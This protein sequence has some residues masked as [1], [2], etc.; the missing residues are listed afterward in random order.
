M[1]G[2][3]N[4]KF[5]TSA[6]GKKKQ[7]EPE[8]LSNGHFVFSVMAL[9][10]RL[11]MHNASLLNMGWTLKTPY[12]VV[13][14]FCFSL[15]DEPSSRKKFQKHEAGVREM[16]LCRGHYDIRSIQLP[17]PNPLGVGIGWSSSGK[18]NKS[19][20]TQGTWAHIFSE[21]CSSTE[22]LPKNNHWVFK[23]QGKSCWVLPQ[24]RVSGC[25]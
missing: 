24:R 16:L 15:A 18:Y 4:P 17:P 1:N 19:K 5:G 20:N 2:S 7:Q 14:S 6:M 13:K 23:P 10:I 25:M 22:A 9:P 12:F 3:R 11:C 8:C 21:L